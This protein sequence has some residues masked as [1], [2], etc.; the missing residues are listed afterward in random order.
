MKFILQGVVSIVSLKMV[1]LP[2]RKPAHADTSHECY[3]AEGHNKR[4]GKFVVQ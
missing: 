3:Y 1:A 2:H 4:E